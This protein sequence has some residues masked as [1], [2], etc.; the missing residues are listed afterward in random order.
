MSEG[1]IGW[2]AM[3]ADRV[4]Y[5]LDHSASG[6]ES[7][8]WRSDLRPSESSP[9]L[10]VLHDRRS[11]QCRWCD[12]THRRRSHHGRERLPARRLDLA[13]HGDAMKANFGHLSEAVVRKVSCQNAAGLFDVPAPPGT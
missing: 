7:R 4:D 13:R 12:R 10:L 8:S 5:V 2:V 1:G 9:E 11:E 6:R 3:L